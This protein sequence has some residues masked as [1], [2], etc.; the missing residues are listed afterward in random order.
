MVDRDEQQDTFTAISLDKI[1]KV[2]SIQLLKLVGFPLTEI[3][4]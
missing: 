1:I 2:V 3:L 4:Q